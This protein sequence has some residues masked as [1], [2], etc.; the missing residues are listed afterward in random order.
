MPS[1][2]DTK[3]F[4]F[5]HPNHFITFEHIIEF[6]ITIGI[7]IFLSFVCAFTYYYKSFIKCLGIYI[8]GKVRAIYL[9]MT[10][11]KNELLNKI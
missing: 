9:S 6:V 7:F 3:V 11:Y 10:V 5:V 1:S 4:V 8:D 2:T